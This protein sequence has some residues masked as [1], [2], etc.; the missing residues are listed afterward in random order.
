MSAST[1]LD[2]RRYDAAEAQEVRHT[3]SAIHCAA[4]TQRIKSGDPFSTDDAFMSRFDSYTAIAGFDLIVACLDG[5]PVGQAWGWPLASDTE[6][7]DGLTTEP[8]PDFTAENGTRTFAFSELMVDRAYT[9]RHIARAL[10]GELLRDRSE[11]RATLL[12][13]PANEAA[14]GIYRR[15]GWRK[16]ASLRPTW[17]DAP[18]FDVLILP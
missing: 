1:G 15:W 14:Y 12:V 7:W 9:G 6:W 17:P 11:A 5:Q 10:H 2:I 18:L 3:V 16:A 4:Y 13:N 8:E